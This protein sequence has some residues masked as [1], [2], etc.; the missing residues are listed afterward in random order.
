MNT[1]FQRYEVRSGGYND[2]SGS[3][4]DAVPAR[5]SHVGNDRSNGRVISVRSGSSKDASINRLESANKR[6]SG[7]VPRGDTL[8]SAADRGSKR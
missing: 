8:S 2:R 7:D 3:T 6:L 5:D 4:S 1:K